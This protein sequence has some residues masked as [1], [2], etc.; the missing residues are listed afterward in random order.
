M[1][2]HRT[3]AYFSMEIAIDEEIPTYSGG[4]GVLAGDTVKAAADLKLPFVAITLMSKKGYFKQTLSNGG[5]Q[6]EGDDTWE[7]HDHLEETPFKATITLDGRNIALRPWL[8]RYKSDSGSEVLVYFIDSDLPENDEWDRGLT[9][10][11]YGG[12]DYYRLCQE[13]VLGIGG[14][15]LLRA[16]GYRDIHRY[17][18][19]EGHAA[20][21]TL[22]LHKELSMEFP[23]HDENFIFDAIREKCVFTTHT[24]VPAGHD[25]FPMKLV[26]NVLAQYPSVLNCQERFCFNEQLNLTYQALHHSRYVNGVAKR[27]GSISRQM[28]PQYQIHAITNGVHAETWV[29]PSFATLFERYM[30]GW[31]LDNSS[32]RYALKIP[33]SEIW[34]AHLEAKSKM[35]NAVELRSNEKLDEEVFTLCYARRATAYKRPTLLFHDIAR[36][37]QIAQIAGRIQIIFA[38]KAHPKDEVG[39]S[40]IRDMHEIKKKLDPAIKFVYLSDYNIPLAKLL[41]AGADCWLNTPLPPLEASGTSGMKAALNGVPSLSVLDGWWL[42]GC[43]EGVTGW[44]IGEDSFSD[45]FENIDKAQLNEEHANSL[46]DKLEYKVIPTYTNNHGAYA[47]VMRNCIALNGAFFTTERMLGQ[48][49][50]KAYY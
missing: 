12:D 9:D 27:H 20:L 18:M 31:H 37:N 25:K 39:K 1:E 46:Y 48:Y 33:E 44:A 3:I 35:L 26:A 42:E 49:V 21:L 24:P 50:S 19:N 4:L 45:G 8:Y 41:V 10:H 23:N 29:N 5:Q 22:E 28:Y 16:M 13:A 2:E 32:L 30:E 6:S 36:L 47:K 38:G 40:I 17:H 11:L 43:I 7:T 14:I 15:K 34:Q